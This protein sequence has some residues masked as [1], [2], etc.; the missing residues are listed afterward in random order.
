MTEAISSGLAGRK[1]DALLVS[2]APNIRYLTGFTGDNGSVL[3]TP[4]RT[5]LFTDPRFQ[6]QAAQEVGCE[7]KIA[8]GPLVIDILGS[9]KR[10]GLKRIGYEP[11]RMT[12]DVF[13]S[14]KSRLP[15]R[16][17]L[18]PVNGWVEELRMVKS[19]D[20]IARIRR[21]VATNSE[22]F[23]QAVRRAKPGMKESEL[24]AELE[25]RMRR[26]GAEKPCFDTI[27]A[28]GARSAL[29]HAQPTAARLENG[30]LVVVDMGA[31]QDGYCSDMTRMLF[32][33]TPGAKVKRTY[34]AVL[35]AQLAAID[36]VRAGALTRNVDRAA[37]QVLKRHGLDR[38]FVHSTGHGLGLE[39]HEPPRVGRKDKT[40][41]QAGM[42]I[43][44]EP[45]VYLERF[46]G[47]RIEDTVLVTNTGCEILTPTPKELR[48]I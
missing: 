16:A 6:I 20:E 10:L 27:V 31:L 48:I 37:R 24:A 47:I 21:S 18:E 22:A 17:S 44:I 3:V 40:R 42:A 26:L 46:G 38:A 36:A 33:G 11:A 32:L 19:P 34:A 12:C 7:V 8:K 35:E 13:E 29:P 25:Y 23:E 2:G 41:L 43:T 15:L 30:Q 45:G 9:V 5:I 28:G 1:L 14:L 39:I 4:E